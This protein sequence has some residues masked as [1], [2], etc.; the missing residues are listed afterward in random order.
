ME[1]PLF[2]MARRA[3]HSVSYLLSALLI[4]SALFSSSIQTM[5]ARAAV[6]EFETQ[7]AAGDLDPS[8][9]N[10]DKVVTDFSGNDDVGSAVAIEPDGKIVVGGTSTAS[11]GNSDFALCRYNVD[12]GLDPSFGSNGRVITDFFHDKDFLG[13]I[14]IQPDG[15]IVAAG[16]ALEPGVGVEFALARYNLDG[17]LDQSFGS[18]GKTVTRFPEDAEAAAVA[19][20]AAG[21]IVAVGTASIRVKPR[22]A[23]ARYN[24]D[25]TLDTSFG[26]SGIIVNTLHTSQAQAVALQPDNKIVI[27]GQDKDAQNFAV[28]RYNSNGSA[29]TSFGIAGQV[30][31]GSFLISRAHAVALQPDGKIVVAGFGQT[32]VFKDLFGVSRHNTNGS[33]DG[34]FGNL[35]GSLRTLISS[36]DDRATALAIG[37]NGK[38]IVAGFVGAPSDVFQG[39][40]DF[41]VVRYKRQGKLDNSFGTFGKVVT[42]FFGGSDGANAIALQADGKIVLAGTARSATNDFAVARYLVEDFALRFDPPIVTASRGTTVSVDLLIDHVCGFEGS[43]TVTPPDLSAIGV[44][45]K[46]VDQIV[47]THTKKTLNIKIKPTAQVGVHLLTFKGQDE[48]GRSRTATVTLTIQ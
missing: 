15:K 26:T 46:P 43:V 6:Q 3:R 44:T 2:K 35:G 19:L 48:E 27:A 40:A 45:L 7:S 13:G 10:G 20:T 36:R 9:G 12:G 29:D 30:I 32:S 4:V 14:A 47:T 25:G 22:V 8:F 17:S 39:F 1:T 41:G 33:F 28:F 38:I 31:S 34:T 24:S 5:P 18:G 11:G 37:S 16:S 21:K 23:L 42:D